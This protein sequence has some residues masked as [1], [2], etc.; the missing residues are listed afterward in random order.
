MQDLKLKF[1]DWSESVIRFIDISFFIIA[2]LAIASLVASYGFYLSSQTESI[3]ERIDLLIVLFFVFQYFLKLTF[4][5]T[6]KIFI[7][8]HWFESSLVVLILARTVFLFHLLGVQQIGD[9]FLNIDV[10]TIT[11][12]TVI[13]AQIIIVLSIIS[14]SMRFNRK[15][16]SLRF[17]PSQTLLMSFVIVILIGTFLLLLPKAVAAGKSL[18]FL[19]ALF[20]AT[21]ATC[22]T[23]LIVVDTGTHFSLLGQLIILT[24][25]QIGGLGLMTLS[26]FLALFFG[27]GMGIKER[28]VLQE[29][30]NID[31]LGMITRALRLAVTI[32]FTFEAVGATLLYFSWD[33][34]QWTF[35]QHVYHSVFHAV[36]AFC[37]AGFSLNANSLMNYNNNYAVMLTIA[38]LIIFGGLGFVVLIELG[39]IRI[40]PAGKQKKHWSVQTKLVLI[41]TALLLIGG[42]FILLFVQPFKGDFFHRLMQAFFSSVTARTAGFNTVDFSRFSIPAAL[43]IVLLMF[44]GASPGS[45]GGGIKT[46]TVGIFFASLIS[47]LTGKNRIELFHKSISYTILNRALVIF[48]FSILV[49]GT[50]IFLL[51]ITEKAP[52]INI[53]FEEISAYG[54]VGLSRGLTPHLTQWGRIILIFSMLIGRVGALTLA[55]AIIPPKEKLRVE[56]PTEKSMMVG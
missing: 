54:T 1:Y 2:L 30:M 35:G 47:I 15:I 42:T 13:S 12:L 18:N 52:L 55:F 29:M 22:V 5:H 19:D 41:I 39:G 7:R 11:Q 8:R 40:R 46:T 9:Y 23:G 31:R 56:Y 4:S 51:T 36:S 38:T 33:N 24:L 14:G 32:T 16:A 49:V 45:T 26:S 43:L 37:N 27:R 25:I 53:V 20:T 44:I 3:L 28:V 17:H 50:S 10:N 21:S 48:T 6:K 34:P